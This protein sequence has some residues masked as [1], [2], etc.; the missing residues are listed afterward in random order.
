MAKTITITLSNA[1]LRAME[2]DVIDPEQWVRDAV[3]GKIAS[4]TRRITQEAVT[5]LSNDPAV[6]TMPA[7][8]AQLIAELVKRPDY[9]NRRRRDEDERATRQ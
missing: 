9:K 7:K 1:D 8:S 6:E 5:V 2:H 4:C 3:A